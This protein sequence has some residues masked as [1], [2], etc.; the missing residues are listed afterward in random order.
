[1]VASGGSHKGLLVSFLGDLERSAKAGVPVYQL[2]GGAG[3]LWVATFNHE[4]RGVLRFLTIDASQIAPRV[5]AQNA[6][7]PP[8]QAPVPQAPLARP[9]EAPPLHGG[10]PPE[11]GT[12]ARSPSVFPSTPAGQADTSFG[13]SR[14]DQAPSTRTVEVTASGDTTDAAQKEAAREA[15]QQVAGIFIDDRRRVEINMSD[16]KVHEIVEEKL[17]SYTNAYVSQF[18]VLSSESNSGVYT[19]KARV[20]VAVAPLLKTLQ[21]NDVPTTRFDSN[22]AAATATTL[23]DEK[24][25]ALQI[26]RDLV[27]RLDSL[28]QIGI[29]KAEVSPSIPSAPDST[30]ISVPITF[31]ANEDAA[32]EWRKKFELIADKH[33]RIVIEVV[34]GGTFA[35]LPAGCAL[36]QASAFRTMQTFLM[37]TPGS[38][39]TG[40]AAC[41]ISGATSVRHD[42]GM[43]PGL[44]ADCFGRAFVLQTTARVPVGNDTDISVAQR[45]AL[46]RLVVNFIDKNG[47]S[48]YS[49]ETPFSNFPSMAIRNSQSA[50]KQ[51]QTAFFNYCERK[52]SKCFF[53]SAYKRAFTVTDGRCW[54]YLFW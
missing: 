16:Q 9:S 34:N 44:I 48:V 47:S 22:S 53:P 12:H 25:N 21:A 17:L 6:P 24:K 3:L 35:P 54:Q 51:G 29:G 20:T 52:Q 2:A 38:G 37:N 36:P 32:Q 30:W 43:G 14:V 15:V 13:A 23:A 49:L 46:V 42:N 4:G 50:P 31:F 1:M 26:Y 18:L 45:A 39:E 28:V 19:I 33:A 40:V 5:V 10:L 7:A 41:F 27:A 11:S 8:P